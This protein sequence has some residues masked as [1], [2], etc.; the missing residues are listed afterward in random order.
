MALA[1]MSSYAQNT[2][3]TGINTRMNTEKEPTRDL[4]ISFKALFMDYQ[5]QNGGS[6]TRFKDYHKGF[7][8]NVQKK[9]NDNI[10][11]VVPFKL[12]V[13]N[14]TII[15]EDKEYLRKMVY[16]LDLQAHYGFKTEG[17]LAEPYI[18]AGIGGVQEKGGPFNIQIPIGA[19]LKVPVFNKHA[20]INYQV[21]YRYGLTEGRTNLHHGI[22]FIYML[23]PDKME[24]KT[25]SNKLDSDGDGVED[26]VDLCPNVPGLPEFNGC[27]DSDGD[28]I[29]DYQDLC[30]E[31]K[32]TAEMRGCPDSDGDGVPDHE[33]KCPN[34]PGTKENN[35]CPGTLGD[36]D[37]DGILDSIDKCPDEPG[38]LKNE[39]CP[40]PVNQ[41]KDGD[42]VPDSIDRCPNIPGTARNN[43]CPEPQASKDSDGD[44]VPDSEDECPNKPGPKVYNGCPDSDGDGIH[45]GRDKCP[46]SRGSVA[47]GGCPEVSKEDRQTLDIAMRAVQFDSGRDRLKPESYDV[48][49]KVFNILNRYPD[50]NLVIEGHT[51]N[52]GSASNNQRLSEKRAKACMDY[53]IKKG[54]SSRRIS[55]AGYGETRPVADNNTLRGRTLNRRVE[56][57]MIAPN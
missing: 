2:T 21:E 4:G 55:H 47:T 27:P 44:G 17:Y 5:S 35:G 3:T 26:A 40:E 56:F 50:Y 57:R 32:G 39:G 19:G 45:D 24:D 7:E 52:T 25:M 33:D 43:G 9:I 31:A 15:E 20:Y 12:G 29:P 6:F 16:G 23:G 8:V 30:P 54:I 11:L 22:G 34:Q 51:D 49:G 18:L 10:I 14:D 36:R 48:L 38:T 37:G 13:V 1:C 42:G 53:L 28:G 41:D 46:N